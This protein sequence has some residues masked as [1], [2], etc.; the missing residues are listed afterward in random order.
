[1]P[2]QKKNQ[3]LPLPAHV[4]DKY[5]TDDAGSNCNATNDGSTQQSLLGDLVVDQR[6]QVCRLE[7]RRLLAEQQVIVPSRLCVVSEF[8]VAQG[9]VVQAFTAAFGGCAEYF[10]EEHDPQLLVGSRTGFDEALWMRCSAS[11]L[12]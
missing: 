5:S 8:V 2:R 6:P 12:E 9:E 10:G 4:P 1:M 11:T 3:K 7:V